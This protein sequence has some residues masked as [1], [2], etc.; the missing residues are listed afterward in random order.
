VRSLAAVLLVVSAIGG[1]SAKSEPCTDVTGMDTPTLMRTTALSRATRE[2]DCEATG[3]TYTE[4]SAVG[5]SYKAQYGVRVSGCGRVLEYECDVIGWEMRDNNECVQYA[6]CELAHG[7][8]PRPMTD[9]GVD[10]D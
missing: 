8:W 1:C 6:N 2:L 7:D 5:P 4:L 3:L 10:S 9:A